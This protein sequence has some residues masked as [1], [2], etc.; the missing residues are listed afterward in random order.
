MWKSW[1]QQRLYSHVRMRI[2]RKIMPKKNPNSLVIRLSQEWH[3][4][5]C[6]QTPSL[7]AIGNIVTGTDE[8]TQTVLD[9]GALSMFHK[10]LPHKKCNVQKEAAWTLSNITAGQHSQIQEV[11]NSGLV[12]D[13]VKL[14][15]NVCTLRYLKKIHPIVVCY[16]SS[17]FLFS[18]GWLQNPERGC[19]GCYQLHQWGHRWAGG[20]SC[21]S[22]SSGAT[23]E[24]AFVQRCQNNPCHFGCHY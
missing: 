1:L 12:P 13:L 23:P 15:V 14:L 18:A 8:Q 19:V 24:S 17:V 20:L 10:L 4:S 5:V 6:F 11:I 3:L 22:Q 16:S 21:S 2:V 7:R 9:S